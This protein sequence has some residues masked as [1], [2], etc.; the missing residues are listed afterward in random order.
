MARLAGGLA[1]PSLSRWIS[2][3]S[4]VAMATLALH[5]IAAAGGL[6]RTHRTPEALCLCPGM[7]AVARRT[8]S[9]AVHRGS[10]C[11]IY[12]AGVLCVHCGCEALDPAD[13]RHG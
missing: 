6:E 10:R 9:P 4:H 1:Q 2:Y 8:R 7:A 3:G 5:R 13:S 11:G 12:H